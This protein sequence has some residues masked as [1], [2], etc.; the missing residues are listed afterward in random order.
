MAKTVRL[1][2]LEEEELTKVCLKINRELVKMGR[3]PLRDTEMFHIILEESL[4]NG[5]IELKRDGR[6][7]VIAR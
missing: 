6:V 5:I 1:N 7:R 4:I 2:D 3:M